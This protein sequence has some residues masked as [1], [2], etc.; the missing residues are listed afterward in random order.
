[1]VLA[2]DQL[3]AS[4]AERIMAQKQYDQDVIDFKKNEEEYEKEL[5][6][7]NKNVK[8]AEEAEA[9]R[10]ESERA[11]IE[12]CSSECFG[13]LDGKFEN[14][15]ENGVWRIVASTNSQLNQGLPLLAF[16]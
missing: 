2:Q 4:Q 14:C 7:Y 3:Q 10:I 8:A 6:Q 15:T 16:Y 5:V 12:P 13:I 1:M 9:K 11:E